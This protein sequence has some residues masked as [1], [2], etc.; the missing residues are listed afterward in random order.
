MPSGNLL[1]NLSDL[2]WRPV[3]REVD[4]AL[5][6]D[7]GPSGAGGRNVE[8]ELSPGG[9][10][11]IELEGIPNRG[12]PG[13]L[14]FLR[15]ASRGYLDFSFAQFIT[16][17]DQKALQDVLMVRNPKHVKT[18][19]APAFGG[20]PAK[21]RDWL[22][23]ARMMAPAQED[24][25]LVGKSGGDLYDALRDERKAGMLNVCAKATHTGTVGGLWE[26]I[27]E[28]L[29]FRRDRCFVR[30]D[31]RLPQFLADDEHFVPAPNTLHDP[32]PGYRLSNSVKSDD[33]HANIQVTLQ[34]AKD[35]SFA[36]D[37]DIDES[38]GFAHWGEVLRNFFSRQRTN[39]YAIHELL[40]AADLQEQTLDPG[41]EL[42]LK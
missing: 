11:E 18:I 34:Q 10:T 25:D 6:R 14:Y 7:S 5:S 27:G 13:S 22:S 37:V 16:E 12:G 38:S 41:Y 9:E 32:L 30:V 42:V 19:D 23:S 8:F 20:L 36:A 33:K 4:I 1:V 39:P 40:L 24:K 15:F 31:S 26:F 28:P 3:D 2:R 21:L 35:G 29:V 17:G